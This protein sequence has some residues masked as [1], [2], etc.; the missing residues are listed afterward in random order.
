M[1][2]ISNELAI[3]PPSHMRMKALSTE[4]PFD[5][6]HFA[7]LNHEFHQVICGACPNAHLL[8][9]LAKQRDR[10]ILVRR[11]VFPFQAQ[12]SRVSVTEHAHLL[13]LISSG[14]DSAEV[15]IVARR[16]KLRTM[17]EFVEDHFPNGTAPLS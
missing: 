9:V 16:H 11:N 2:R 13:K 8:R 12:R 10:V 4:A 17:A 6:L 3:M 14:A 15:E 1:L 7:N 5:P